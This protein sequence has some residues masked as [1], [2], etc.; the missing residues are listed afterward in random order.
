VSPNPARATPDRKLF[1]IM[2]V[3]LTGI[4]D[5]QGLLLDQ[6]HNNKQTSKQTSKMTSYG[7]SN[8]TASLHLRLPKSLLAEVKVLAR[9]QDCGGMSSFVRRAV[10]AYMMMQHPNMR[11]SSEQKPTTVIAEPSSSPDADLEFLKKADPSYLK[12]LENSDF[13]IHARRNLAAER[14]K[15]L[16]NQS[17][18]KQTEQRPMTAEEMLASVRTPTPQ[19]QR[20]AFDPSSCEGNST[21]DPFMGKAR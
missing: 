7:I 20:Q 17:P 18:P 16:R 5:Q 10:K 6:T 15:A 9:E 13:N 3:G 14:V 21:V 19:P 1:Y 8:A 4:L 11:P 2:H 12:Y